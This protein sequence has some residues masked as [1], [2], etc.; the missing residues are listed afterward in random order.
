MVARGKAQHHG[1]V[2]LVRLRLL[3]AAWVLLATVPGLAVGFTTADLVDVT[4]GWVIGVWVAGFVAQLVAYMAAARVADMSTNVL[5]ALM[6]SLGP[7]VVDW[8]FAFGWWLPVVATVEFVAFAVWLYGRASFADALQR[9]GVRARA[10]VLEVK[11]GLMNVVVNNIYVRRTLRVRVVREDGAAP[12]ETT[13]RGLFELGTV[14]DPGD[15]FAVVVDPARPQRIAAAK[16][17]QV[18]PAADGPAFTR[19]APGTRFT[20]WHGAVPRPAAADG[21]DGRSLADNLALLAQ[22]HGRG[23]LTDAEYAEAKRNLLGAED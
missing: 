3:L 19:V 21:P 15:D 5:G 12:Y 17:G 10:E 9:D 16:R 11:R 2:N 4:A 14:P 1:G 13:F 6:M 20:S 18:P 8:G 22:L 7:F 23:E